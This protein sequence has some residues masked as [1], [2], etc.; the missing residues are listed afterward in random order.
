MIN[1]FEFINKRLNCNRDNVL[2]S[3]AIDLMHA[4]NPLHITFAPVPKVQR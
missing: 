2:M 4:N 3:N 1:L